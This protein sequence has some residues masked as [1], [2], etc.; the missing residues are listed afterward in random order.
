MPPYRTRLSC[1]I[2][3]LYRYYSRF[4]SNACARN[5]FAFVAIP[6]IENYSSRRYHVASL[7][8]IILRVR[9]W[10]HIDA[11][12]SRKYLTNPLHDDCSS[13]CGIASMSLITLRFQ[14]QADMGG[15]PSFNGFRLSLSN[16]A[17]SLYKTDVTI[18]RW[19]NRYNSPLKTNVPAFRQIVFVT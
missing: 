19:H 4:E 6:R 2:K 8:L 10:R 18:C 12:Q 11:T 5:I 7:G 1:T 9:V 14:G 15:L 16:L 3:F 13:I 17:F